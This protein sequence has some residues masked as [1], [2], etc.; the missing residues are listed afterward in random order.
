MDSNL[1]KSEP[2][3]SAR[4]EEGKREAVEDEEA[5][6]VEAWADLAEEQEGS[7]ADSGEVRFRFALGGQVT[8]DK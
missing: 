1:L 3:S 6:A 4:A 7:A 5:S 2:D 8:S